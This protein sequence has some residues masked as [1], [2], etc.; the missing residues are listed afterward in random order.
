M[1]AKDRITRLIVYS[2]AAVIVL[3]Y[4][5]YEINSCNSHKRL[6][7]GCIERLEQI[8]TAKEEWALEQ[9][10]TPGDTPTW[11]DIRPF[12]KYG[13]TNTYCTNGILYCPYGGSY[14]IGRVGEPATCSIGGPGHSF[15]P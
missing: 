5:A 14:T 3:G 11:D 8:D 13:L 12:L 1:R 2:I 9:H 4:L 15:Q 6:P 10:K 7:L